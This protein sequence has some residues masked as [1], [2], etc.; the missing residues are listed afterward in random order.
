L[1]A[2]LATDTMSDPSSAWRKVAT[3]NPSMNVAANQNNDALIT[4][5]N[6][7][8]VTIVIGKVSMTKIGRTKRFRSPSTTAATKAG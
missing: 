3:A 7:P 5:I 8:K 2:A 1:N 4:N 6:S